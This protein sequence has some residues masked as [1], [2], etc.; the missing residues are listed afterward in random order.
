[1]TT[2]YK[3]FF[4]SWFFILPINEHFVLSINKYFSLNFYHRFDFGVILE[5]QNTCVWTFPMRFI[6]VAN[7]VCH[8]A[9][10]HMA[11]TFTPKQKHSKNC[12]HFERPS[13]RNESLLVQLQYTIW[14]QHYAHRRL[15][16]GTGTWPSPCYSRHQ[17][18]HW[19]QVTGDICWCTMLVSSAS[20]CPP[21]TSSSLSRVTFTV[22]VTVTVNRCGFDFPHTG[23][24]A[25][26]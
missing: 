7:A 4:L 1:M 19:I 5:Q 26:V 8:T 6:Y 15:F 23:T 9:V 22:T 25:R 17:V 14:L 20:H 18:E 11:L 3:P 16:R 12:T 10:L 24:D 2:F 13:S 21:R